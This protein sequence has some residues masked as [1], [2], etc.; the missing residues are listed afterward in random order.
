MRFFEE[1]RKQFLAFPDVETILPKRADKG[2]AGYDFYTKVDILLLPGESILLPTDVKAFFPENEVL[3]CFI[4]SSIGNNFNVQLKNGTG[5]ID[6]SFYNNPKN[7]GNIHLP[8][9]NNGSDAFFIAAGER[10]M[11]AIF[12]PYYLTNDDETILESR[13]GGLGSSGK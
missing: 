6:S 7:D 2:S 1:V 5:I 8:L 4:R 12:L 11:Q 13:S 3:M 9:I 10:I